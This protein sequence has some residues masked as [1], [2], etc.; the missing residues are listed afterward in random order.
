[1]KTKI[2]TIRI[3][4]SIIEKT[5]E[6]VKEFLGEENIGKVYLPGDWNN[7]GN[8]PEK[9]GCIRPKSEMEMHLEEDCYITKVELTIGIHKFKPA[10]ISAT[11][12]QKGMSPAI[13]IACPVEGLGEYEQEKSDIFANWI[14]KVN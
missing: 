7:W 4:K 11:P 5:V 10:I 13:W 2:V 6:E 1:M 3:P 12:D 8:S 9:A 14:V